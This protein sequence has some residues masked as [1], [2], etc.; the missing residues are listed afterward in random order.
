MSSA[1]PGPTP[2]LITPEPIIEHRLTRADGRP[3]APVRILHLGLGNFFRAHTCWYTE[4][5]PDADQWGI[6]AFCGRSATHVA[7]LRSQDD[8]YTL[9]IQGP[10]TRAEIVST[11]SAVHEAADLLA[12]RDYFTR[13]EVGLVTSS[14]T[15]GGYLRDGAG[16][17]DIALAQVQADAAALRRDPLLAPVMTAP[18]KFVAGLLARRQAGAGPI[19]FLP[20]DNV[21]SSGDMIRTVVTQ[22]ARLVDP[23]LV[24]WI[25]HNVGF[26]SAMVDRITPGPTPTDLAQASQLTGF[27]DP[28]AV[29]TEPFTEW[30]M[31]GEFRTPHPDWAAVGAQFVDDIVPFEHRKLWLLNGAH[32]LMAYVGPLRGHTTVQEA[33]ADPVMA[34]WVTSWW[35]EA[36]RHL[37]VSQEDVL[38]YR[39]ALEERFRNPAMRDVLARIAADGSQKIPIR[40]VPI[41]RAELADGRLPIAA[42]RGVAAWVC[43]LRGQSTAVKD[44]RQ[45]EVE[46]LADGSLEQCVSAVL[47]FLE[48]PPCLG[49]EVVALTQ[50]LV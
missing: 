29:V 27:D 26:I 47:E 2:D 10:R 40:W 24:D 34:E 8:L 25:D 16:D 49:N 6:A 1:E 15:E 48:L 19:T 42:L 21:V 22:M 39:S 9:L 5:A 45:A 14:I 41:I 38:A 37:P 11:L 46:A 44:T 31:E 35:D 36:C 33:I 23:S 17:L 3:K 18:G 50:D 7:D 4:H 20:C 13:P 32:S 43:H 28:A 12:W 30:V